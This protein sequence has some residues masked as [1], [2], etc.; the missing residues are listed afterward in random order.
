MTAGVA[1]QSL[2]R[3]EFQRKAHT[4]DLI[5]VGIGIVQARLREFDGIARRESARVRDAVGSRHRVDVA[6]VPSVEDACK[7]GEVIIYDRA[8]ELEA[9]L[10]AIPAL[11][12]VKTLGAGIFGVGAEIRLRQD[13]AHCTA[14]GA[15]AEE[16]A[17]RAAQHLDAL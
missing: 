5:P 16:S 4:L 2:E 10:T 11:I 6:S 15:R 13:G 14:L 9:C 3:L 17:L 7:E 12:D 1:L 8:A